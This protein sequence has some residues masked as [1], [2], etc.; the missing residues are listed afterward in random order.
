[1]AIETFT[2]CA[3][4]EPVGQVDFRVKSSK[5]G[6]GYEQRAQDGINNKSQ[7]WPLTFVAK[8]AQIKEIRDFLDRQAGASPFYWTAPLADQL[9]YRCKTYQITPM[10]ADMYTLSATFEQAF[11]P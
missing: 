10:G 2:W 8:E 3:K 7:S 9:L 6:D 4:I 11:H 5:F 1:M